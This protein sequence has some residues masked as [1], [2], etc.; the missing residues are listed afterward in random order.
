M[1]F[2]KHIKD[3]SSV[4]LSF[5]SNLGV[6]AKHIQIQ[7]TRKE[8]KG[9][10]TVVVFPLLSFSNNNLEETAHELGLDL[11]KN[12][13][14]VSSF[15]IVKGFLNL[16]FS[17][18]F[19]FDVLKF[20]F[21]ENFELNKSKDKN[22]VVEFSSP[23]TNKP[24][25]LGHLRNILLGNA[26]SNILEADGN[27][28][29]RVQ[30]I[31][32]R[33]IHVCKSMLAWSKFGNGETPESTG[34]KGDFFVGKYYV[35]F[36]KKYQEEQKKLIQDGYSIEEAKSK[37]TLLNDTKDMLLKWESED[38][39]IIALWKQMNAWVYNGFHETYE[40]LGISFDKNYYESETYLIGKKHVLA[41][42]K[43]GVFMS[44]SDSSVWA[45]LTGS[46]L[47]KK[48]LLRSDGTTVYMTQDIGTAIL[49]HQ[50]FNFHQM[51]YTVGNEQNYHFD[52]LFKIL[53][54]MGIDWSSNLCHLSYG[55]VHLP[56]GKMKSRE[57]TVVDVDDLV[58]EVH[59]QAKN[60]IL[61]SDRGVG[62]QEL[63][64][65]EIN[66]LSMIVGDAALKYFILKTDAKKNMLFNTEESIDFN[67]HTG[68]FIQYTYARIQ[69]ILSKFK[70]NSL[71]F[72]V[73]RILSEEEKK[74]IQLI[75]DYP[76]VIN[77]ASVNLNPSSLANYL[78][79]LAKSYNHFYQKNRIL[80]LEN[81]NDMNFR[82]TVSEKVS[83]LIYNGMHLL[84]ISVPN[85]M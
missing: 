28:V 77:Q 46:G 24:L 35:L 9:D 5:Y 22:I 61:A 20:S 66:R 74:L 83:N 60:I 75:L 76:I 62:V 53:G 56:E 13:K 33:G 26:I 58:S 29:N 47:D 11:Q 25:H 39:Q 8:F 71:L 81:K 41:G 65:S 17:D 55:M 78:Y 82:V 38:E 32:D 45:D 10:W 52:V 72:E 7:K 84:G 54:K 51:I 14:Y 18:T 49:R 48:I 43:K 6:S 64:N 68:P 16:E 73:N 37:S 50:D 31:N 36:E 3:I 30:I 34:V 21:L 12:I 19:W 40:K 67:G 70:K 85:K 2:D 27:N 15:N 23:N 79:A 4:I 57:G 80:N 44:E 42:L 59:T 63:N 69:S 1:I